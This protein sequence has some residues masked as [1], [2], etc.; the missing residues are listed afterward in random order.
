MQVPMEAACRE[1]KGNHCAKN[2]ERALTC[3]TAWAD[4]KPTFDLLGADAVDTN[5]PASKRRQ[6]DARR[7]RVA[8]WIETLADVFKP[9]LH[10]FDLRAK[11]MS[12]AA[13]AS[14][15]HADWLNRLPGPHDDSDKA[16]GTLL[17]A[18]LEEASSKL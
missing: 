13:A 4:V 9:W 6:S 5:A 3:A 12:A 2:M 14:E 11:D 8:T 18:A 7:K 1:I 15:K 17:E 10:I 16:S